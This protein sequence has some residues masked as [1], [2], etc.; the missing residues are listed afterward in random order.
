MNDNQTK[1][2]FDKLK[3]NLKEGFGKLSDNESMESEGKVDQ[4]KGSVRQKFG[5]AKEKLAGTFNDAVD[6]NK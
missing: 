2:T 6:K 1:G 3:G 4:A 5:E